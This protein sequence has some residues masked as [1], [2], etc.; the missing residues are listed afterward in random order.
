MSDSEKQQEH[1]RESKGEGSESDSDYVEDPS[2]DNNADYDNEEMSD[3]LSQPVATTQRQASQD[4]R[5]CWVCFATDEDDAAAVWVHPCR[6]NA[7]ISFLVH[8]TN[9]ELNSRC[10]GTTKWVHQACIQRWVDE[11]QKGNNFAEVTCPQCG[12][13]YIIKLPQANVIVRLLDTSERLI[14]RLCPV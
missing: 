12:T 10:R 8:L 2:G 13:T 11:K 5:Q 1:L 14:Q 4:E 9:L 7:S 3:H 6:Y